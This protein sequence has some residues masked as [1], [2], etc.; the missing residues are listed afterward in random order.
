MNM[1]VPTISHEDMLQPPIKWSTEYHTSHDWPVKWRQI[2]IESLVSQHWLWRHQIWLYWRC[3]WWRRRW[4]QGFS[5]WSWSSVLMEMGPWRW[6]PFSKWSWLERGSVYRRVVWS[7]R[8]LYLG[9]QL[10]Y[11][12]C[13]LPQLDILA[14]HFLPCCTI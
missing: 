14:V 8:G 3:N 11:R 13:P 2:P 6:G 5:R 10:F 4:W 12:C 9:C 1:A 7:S